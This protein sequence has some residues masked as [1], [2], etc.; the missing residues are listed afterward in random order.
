MPKKK[1]APPAD[2]NS[3]TLLLPADA[4][5]R[6]DDLR[7]ELGYATTMQVARE[8]IEWYLRVRGVPEAQAL[9]GL[10][11]RVREVLQLIGAGRSTKQIA[12]RLGITV[13]TVEMHRTQLMKTLNIRGIASLVRFGIRSG[14]VRLDD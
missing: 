6:L 10:T 2:A 11:P 5:Q 7:V 9:A 12:A 8:A 4:L 1:T 14:L 3:L 13:K